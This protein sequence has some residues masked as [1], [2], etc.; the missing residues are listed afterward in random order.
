M[1]KMLVR[2]VRTSCSSVSSS[3]PST[4]C[5]SAALLTRMSIRPKRCDG[6]A[7]WPRGRTARSRCRRR[8]SRPRFLLRST[9]RCGLARRPRARRDRGSRSARLRAPCRRR[10]RGRCRCRRPR[11][12]PPCPRAGPRPESAA[13]SPA[14]AA[15]RTRCRAA[16]LLLRWKGLLPVAH[17]ALTPEEQAAP[18]HVLTHV[19]GKLDD[20][21]E[22]ALAEIGEQ[23]DLP[24]G[25]FQRIM[26]EK[27]VALVHLAEAG[28]AAVILVRLKQEAEQAAKATG[29]S[30]TSSVPGLR[31]TATSRS[32]C[33][34]E[35]ARGGA[36]KGRG[37]QPVALEGGPAPLRSR[38]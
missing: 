6:A 7:R 26:V 14:R 25:E 37:H 11:S 32:S 2:K 9:I 10:R 28:R 18:P 13:C 29:L 8:R 34:A 35:T 20:G 38:L 22:L 27:R 21:R 24:I 4:V 30:N 12:P 5:C 1:L 15:S 3:R 33:R 23:D 17:S 16:F 36:G 31:H 19:P